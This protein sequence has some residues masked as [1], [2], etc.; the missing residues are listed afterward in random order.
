MKNIF[1]LLLLLIFLV[2]LSACCFVDPMTR[3]QN[4]AGKGKFEEAVKVLENEYK[5]QPN[6]VPIKSLLAQA[7][8]DYGLALCQDQNKP[9]KV[10]YPMA[11]EQ[12][13]MALALNPYLKDAK[14]MYEMIEK[15][16][17]SFSANKID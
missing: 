13:A 2:L 16:Q 3:A 7:Y 4:L 9:P 15:I 10:K 8:S 11:K 5:K 6:S 14:D 1:T 12:F 17:T